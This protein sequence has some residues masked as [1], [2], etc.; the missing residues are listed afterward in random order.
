MCPA[1]G[2]LH[3]LLLDKPFAEHGV[4]RRLHKRGRN[5]L[6]APIPLAIVGNEAPIVLDIRA[7]LLHGSF[8][9]GE[10]WVAGGK[11]VHTPVKLPEAGQG[12]VDFAMP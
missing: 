6:S 11:V 4:N 5:R 1:F 2:P 12:V 3:G 9:L 7:E 10:A 8:E